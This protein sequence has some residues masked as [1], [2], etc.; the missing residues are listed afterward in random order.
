M[1]EPATTL[2]NRA[3]FE[4]MRRLDSAIK[5]RKSAVRQFSCSKIEDPALGRSLVIRGMSSP[6]HPGILLWGWAFFA[7]WVAG[8]GVS[9]RD[10]VQEMSVARQILGGQQVI[11][12]VAASEGGPGPRYR[13][14]CSEISRVL[15]SLSE[16]NWV[17]LL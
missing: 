10:E 8:V 11:V 16:K 7:Y 13:H 2:V 15:S 9:V 1:A 14:P 4:R 3:G 6:G 12:Y 17:Q 5:V